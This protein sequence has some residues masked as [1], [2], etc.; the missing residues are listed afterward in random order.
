[1][2]LILMIFAVSSVFIS[3]IVEYLTNN[4]TFDFSAETGSIYIRENLY[5][6]ALIFLFETFGFGTGTGNLE[7]WM[8]NYSTFQTDS[9]L[10][11]H[12][13]WI[14]ILSTYG[15]L[16]FLLYVIFYYKLVKDLIINIVK[17]KNE[18][19]TSISIGLLC[20]MSSFTINSLSSST[21]ISSEWMWVFWAIII[22]F[23][24][25]TYEERR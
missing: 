16:T 7:Y 20:I 10:A 24:G 25:L 19:I 8:M 5:K 21:L 9:V 12:N 6:N 18:V 17:S 13:W 2:V 23:Q 15:V 1:M 22:S 3:D 11:V 14:E 4:L